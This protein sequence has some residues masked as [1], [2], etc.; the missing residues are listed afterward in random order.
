MDQKIIKKL[1]SMYTH[2]NDLFFCFLIN[3]FIFVDVDSI[4][5]GSGMD[6]GPS[7]GFEFP[8][9]RDR[10][11]FYNGLSR[12]FHASRRNLQLL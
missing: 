3:L 11:A 4:C 8:T 5:G 2:G 6:Y 9:L 7:D 12:G 1:S 10:D